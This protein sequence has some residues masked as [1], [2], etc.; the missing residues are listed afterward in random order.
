VDWGI[1]IAS[2]FWAV[3]LGKLS[4]G[5]VVRELRRVGERR[6]ARD[7]LRAIP[8]LSATT[9]DGTLAR[10][11]G[12]ATPIEGHTLIAP[13]TG[14]A[15]LAHRSRAAA[16][17]GLLQ[18][19]A[20]IERIELCPFS[21]G[22]VEIHSANTR[23]DMPPTPLRPSPAQRDRYDRFLYPIGLHR[24]SRCFGGYGPEFEEIIVTPGLRIT[25]AGLVM[26]EISDRARGELGF[27]DR[28]VRARLVGDAEHPIV[29]G[30][31]VD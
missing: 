5:V 30:R 14:R 11:T 17:G 25:V 29:I 1:A 21:L 8:P 2:L 28:A 9:A 23:L 6:R 15:C 3:P 12:I 7:A 27:R 16:R 13:L 19:I 10:V 4:S 18:G 24:H 26:L 22:E 20:V 31:A